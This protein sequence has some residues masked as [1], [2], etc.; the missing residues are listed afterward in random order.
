MKVCPDLAGDPVTRGLRSAT[1]AWLTGYRV[2]CD[3]VG[4]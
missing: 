3:D 2:R 1:R 4:R